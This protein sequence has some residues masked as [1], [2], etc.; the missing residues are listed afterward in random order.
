MQRKC[1]FLLSIALGLCSCAGAHL[2]PRP[3]TPGKTPL[4]VMTYNVNFGIPCDEPTTTAIERSGADAILLQE[5]TPA[6]EQCLRDR[7]SGTYAHIAFRHSAGAGGL[8]VISRHSFEDKDYVASPIQWF[9][10]WR[11]VVHAPLG[12]LQI[13]QVHLRPQVSD[14]GS[15]VSGYLSTGH[16]RRQEIEHYSPTL[17]LS[18]PTLVA[19]DFNEQGGDAV[20]HLRDQG[21]RD[22]SDDFN[23]GPTWRWPTSVGTLRMKLDHVFYN[24]RV[25]PLDARVL[26]AGRSDHLPVIVVIEA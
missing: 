22:V 4:T 10:A 3:P 23:L 2:Q 7:L 19:G 24:G 26:D 8:A 17:D 25:T 20:R 21:M 12:D 11:V 13:L 18:L 15:Y 1:F 6:W 14:S 16:Y 5:T 9:P